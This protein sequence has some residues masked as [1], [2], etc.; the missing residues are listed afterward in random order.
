MTFSV[1]VHQNE[2][3]ADGAD[4]VHSVIRVVSSGGRKAAV[5]K[6]AVVLVVDTSGSMG[7]P[8]TKIREARTSAAQAIGLLPDGTL[9]A[10]VS[11]TQQARCLYPEGG[12]GLALAD[13][14]TRTEAVHAT[15]QLRANGGTVISTWLDR[16]RSLLEPYPDAIRLAYLVTDGKNEGEPAEAL[17]AAIARAVGIFQCDTRGVGAD[18]S[19]DELRRISTALLGDVDMIRTPEQM[20][21]DFRA[22]MDRAIG[23]DIADVRLRVWT[24]KGSTL[25]LLK[26]V[27]PDIMDLKPAALSVDPLTSDF[28]TGA[29][30]GDERR[31]YHLLV[32]VPPGQIG[33]EKLA[34]RASVLAGDTVAGQGLVR[35]VW[36]DDVER[37][38]RINREVGVYTGRE[39]LA[40]A[41]EEGLEARRRGDVDAAT[42]KLGRAVHLARETGDP[43]KEGYLLKV[44]DVDAHGTVRLKAKVDRLDEM[45]LDTRSTRTVQVP[46]PAPATDSAGRTGTTADR[47]S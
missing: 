25:K 35:A 7:M 32:A 17:D 37:S 21:D 4:E 46:R 44:V 1:E 31:D 6:K 30:S 13:D 24:P 47:G 28:P 18:Y 12:E 11:G 40:D 3:L 41:I 10:L 15:R 42:A 33:D 14:L 45:E 29:W 19:R 39:A 20:D 27:A 38:T 43:V 26:Q 2:Y 22:F 34:A 23:R 36:T 16:V 5:T 9:F 8:S